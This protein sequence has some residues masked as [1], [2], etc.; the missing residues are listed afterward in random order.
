MSSF[1][2]EIIPN[3]DAAAKAGV[4]Y[5]VNT[6]DFNKKQAKG[7]L[8][9]GIKAK[10]GTP[11]RILFPP[12]WIPLDLTQY[13]PVDDLTTSS[14]LREYIRKGLVTLLTE[15]SYKSLIKHPAYATESA[16]VSKI[17]SGF[18]ANMNAHVD[19]ALSAS[20]T[21]MA[22]ANANVE[23]LDTPITNAI[24]SADSNETVIREFD[25][26]LRGLGIGELRTLTS[27]SQPGS[28]IQ[29]IAFELESLIT[30]GQIDSLDGTVTNTQAYKELNQSGALSAPDI[31]F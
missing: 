6:S 20:T 29:R 28:L 10:D 31:S 3:V 5:A 12:T 8:V 1:K 27:K 7:Q 21:P 15:E 19:I 22:D 23:I 4:F 16:R 24:L 17:T 25:K 26:S 2:A 9:I 14:T 13:A 18:V 30:S 11:V